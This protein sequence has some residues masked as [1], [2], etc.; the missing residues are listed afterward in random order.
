MDDVTYHGEKSIPMDFAPFPSNP[1][2]P[3]GFPI[4]TEILCAGKSSAS[5]DTSMDTSDSNFSRVSMHREQL[6]TGTWAQLHPQGVED[7]VDTVDV[8]GLND[9]DDD[10]DDSSSSDQRDP[11]VLDPPK[12]AE[13]R[14]SSFC[15]VFQDGP[16]G[17]AAAAA[18]SAATAT[19][20]PG[21]RGD[22]VNS[23]ADYS[24]AGDDEHLVFDGSGLDDEDSDD[25]GG[26]MPAEASEHSSTVSIASI[27]PVAREKPPRKK[28][29]GK[30]ATV[31]PHPTSRKKPG[32][33]LIR[34]GVLGFVRRSDLAAI[35]PKEYP[36]LNIVA[37]DAPDRT[38]IWGYNRGRK[39]TATGNRYW[40]EFEDFPRSSK[41]IDR[42][43]LRAK[44]GQKFQ[45]VV[46]R[47]KFHVARPNE[48]DEPIEHFVEYFDGLDH[49]AGEKNP[50]AASTRRFTSKTDAEVV[51]MSQ[52]VMEQEGGVE[53]VWDI[54]PEDVIAEIGKEFSFP[55]S[56]PELQNIDWDS[57]AAEVFFESFFPS[58]SGIAAKMDEYIWDPRYPNREA[59]VKEN[60]R[61]NDPTDAD[62]DWRIRQIILLI[63]KGTLYREVSIPLSPT[64]NNIHLG[65][66]CIASE[67]LHVL[68]CIFDRMLLMLLI[69]AGSLP[70]LLN[71]SI[72]LHRMA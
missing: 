72:M 13:G 17:A 20:T 49:A 54:V 50:K 32:R 65:D 26:K 38:P 8:D 64:C 35:L 3:S 53:I 23:D 60:I 71:Y 61:F 56:A 24:G 15:A 46:D 29:R 34:D 5:N 41:D 39:L 36:V 58:L 37:P 27:I 25:G 42:P 6:N 67:E 68:F 55:K 40:I 69:L 14:L 19:R 51:Q 30:G 47:K 59:I 57:S 1:P 16:G 21:R 22:G 28:R 7:L 4:P 43:G 9:T 70:T 66:N 44:K 12:N 33:P 10:D 63:I 31:P 2:D 18:A 11:M 62:P 45:I 48:K 52:F